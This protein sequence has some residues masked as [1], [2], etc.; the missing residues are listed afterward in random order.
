MNYSYYIY[1]SDFF[2][3]VKYLQY[4][5]ITFYTLYFIIFLII[6]YLYC[7]VNYILSFFTFDF[8]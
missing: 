3:T 7:T 6:R 4:I 8:E 5:Y 1:I 2:V